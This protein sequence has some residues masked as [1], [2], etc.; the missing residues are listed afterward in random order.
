VENSG[1]LY[2]TG[3]ENKPKSAYWQAFNL[4]WEFGYMIVIPLVVFALGGRF[5][6]QRL[7]T[8]PWLLLLGMGVAIAITTVMMIRKFSGLV[9][10]IEKQGKA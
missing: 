1:I 4:A 7:G 9:R 2:N 5:A 10:D 8:S 3:M 6:D